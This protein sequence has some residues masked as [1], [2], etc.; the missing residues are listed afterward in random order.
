MGGGPG[1]G[2][3]LYED[4]VS[5]SDSRRT[6]MYG[7]GGAGGAGAGAGGG[8]GSA[9]DAGNPLA[10]MI[11]NPM[12]AAGLNMGRQLLEKNV[13]SYIPGVTAFWNSLRFYF[14]VDHE[15]VRNKLMCLA[16]PF[17][18]TSWE[19][20]SAVDAS[21]SRHEH[22]KFQPPR[23]DVNSPDLYIPL[24][25]FI[26]FILI[27]GLLK[28][29]RGSFTPEVLGEVLTS[30][31]VSQTLEI[32]VMKAGLWVMQCPSLAWL[33]LVAYS[34]YKYLWLTVNTIVGMFAGSLAYYVVLLATGSVMGLF[35]F[36]TI[37]DVVSAPP[38]KLQLLGYGAA[39][40]QFLFMWWLGYS[41]E[42]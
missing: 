1:G 20:R 15:Y 31:V 21:E 35:M 38:A 10:G 14:D 7:G 36:K 40:L 16:M 42:M 24:M 32:I 6:S 39:G 5:M 2:G 8:A 9:G 17:K 18:H 34:G 27:T 25:S 26:T 33:D 13:K 11:S 4:D 30:S 23:G 28:G 22:T 12:A 19:R 37:K 3:G 41:G 29:S